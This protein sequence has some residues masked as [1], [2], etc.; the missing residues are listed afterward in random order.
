MVPED[1][2]FTES[3]EW[4]KIKGEKA[5]VGI[6]DYAVEK[7]GD[8]VYV[9]LPDLE[10]KVKQKE[11][12]GVIESVKAVSDLYSPVSGKIV[13][14]NDKLSNSPDLLNKDPYGEGWI[15]KIE[16]KDINE[17][18]NLLSAKDYKELLEREG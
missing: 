18:N 4:T 14:V 16:V 12:F 17:F 15:L 10:K 5:V 3:H 1:L 9:E 6:T 2:K 7:L 8:I 13:S 11:A